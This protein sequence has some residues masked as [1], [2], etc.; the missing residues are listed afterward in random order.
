MTITAEAVQTSMP[1]AVSAT[2][3]PLPNRR[4]GKVRDV[5][6]LP[7]WGARAERGP[8]LLIVATDRLSAFDVVLPT[9]LPGKGRLLTDI[10]TRWFRFIEQRRICANHLLSTDPAD[11]PGFSEAD[12]APLVGRTTIARRCKV[13]PIEFV[14]RGYLAGSGWKEYQ[15]TG[16]VCGVALPKELRSGE[17]LMDAMGGPIFTPA[18]KEDVGH[19]ENIDFARACAIAGEGVMTRLRDISIKIYLAAHEH[20]LARGLILADTKFEFGYPVDSAGKPEDAILIDE[21]LTPDSSRYWP[22]AGWAPGAKEQ[23][24]FDK[25]F[26]RDYLETLVKKGEWN[27]TPPGPTLPDEIVRKTLAKYEE[28]RT[29]LFG[30]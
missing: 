6:E 15:Q 8:A 17:R 9:P 25:Q 1:N 10:A 26:V 21:A 23:P 27:K 5:Y 22:A 11:I 12:R 14:V 7:S 28:A 29:I 4:Q 13:I 18:T 20:A 3:L 30:A 24:S 16:A 2:R 19:D